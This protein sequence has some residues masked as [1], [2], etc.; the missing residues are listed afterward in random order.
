M[1]EEI[2]EAFK[3]F[4]ESLVKIRECQETWVASYLLDQS[5]GRTRLREGA[6]FEISERCLF[7]EKFLFHEAEFTLGL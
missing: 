3:I 7:G 6:S 2:R 5:I 1:G 4:Y